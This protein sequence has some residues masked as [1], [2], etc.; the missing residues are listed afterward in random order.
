MRKI[1]LQLLLYHHEDFE[2]CFIKIEV[3]RFEFQQL[4]DI[5]TSQ[6]F[7]TFLSMPLSESCKVDPPGN[8]VNYFRITISWQPKNLS[9]LSKQKKTN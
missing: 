9:I 8:F 4:D 7:S 3:F 1:R 6:F 5:K 2:S